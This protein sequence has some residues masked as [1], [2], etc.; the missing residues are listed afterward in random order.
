VTY[1]GI[2]YS[3]EAERDYLEAAIRTAVQIH[4]CEPTG[5]ILIFLTGEDEIEQ[6][7]AKITAELQGQSGSEVGPVVCVPLYSALPPQDQQKV[8]F[9][10]FGDSG[11]DLCA[12]CV[13]LRESK[14][15]SRLETPNPILYTWKPKP[16]IWSC[17][18]TQNSRP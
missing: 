14:K 18:K 3:Q 8:S 2:F 9:L 6:A 15:F 1:F 5:D 13:R 16:G 12:V 11:F 7:C 4:L 10:G 17:P